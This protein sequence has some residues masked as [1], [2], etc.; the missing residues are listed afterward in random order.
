MK[1]ARGVPKAGWKPVV[2]LIPAFF[3]VFLVPSTLSMLGFDRI[4]AASGGLIT[5]TL[6]NTWAGI[7]ICVGGVA[8]W[9]G[10]LCPE[11]IGFVPR[12]LPVA[13]AIVAGC[14]MV[15][16]LAQVVAG[17]VVGDFSL[18][19]TWTDPGVLGTI[20]EAL[21]YFL[22]NAPFEELAFRGFLLVQLYLL[23]DSDWWQS[24]ELVRTASAVGGSSLVFT[25]IHVPAFLLGG[26]GLETLLAIF[27][28]AILLSL[29]YLRTRNLFLAIGFHALA[30]FSIPLFAVA[31]TVPLPVD[32]SILWVIPGVLVVLA[33]PKLQL[34]TRSQ[35]GQTATQQETF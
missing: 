5:Y 33:W 4:V 19:P 34:G 1:V 31:E 35:A 8:L 9:Y 15:Y 3:F 7:A 29:V 24:R 12:K 10:S 22:G 13:A 16:T 2:L 21:G 6:V 14:W 27:V 11:D 23:L 32:L 28:Y 20:G 30:N 17:F 25:L 26:I 18:H